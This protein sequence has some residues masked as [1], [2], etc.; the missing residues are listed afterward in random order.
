MYSGD[1]PGRNQFLP[2][3]WSG[4]SREGA[5]PPTPAGAGRALGWGAPP[6]CGPSAVW[7]FLPPVNGI[8]GSKD[9]TVPLGPRS[10]GLT[11]EEKG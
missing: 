3:A 11:L 6:A 9:H 4:G 2:W 10:Q 5:P 1:C 7:L 8:L